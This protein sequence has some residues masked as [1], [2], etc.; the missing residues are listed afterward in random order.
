[1]RMMGLSDTIMW[2]AWCIQ[3]F[4]IVFFTT[5]LLTIVLK[6]GLSWSTMNSQY[7][8]LNTATIGGIMNILLIGTV[9][10]ALLTWYIENVFPGEFGVPN[11]PWF[12]LTAQYWTGKSSDYVSIRSLID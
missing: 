5:S 3:R 9:I 1:M 8:A 4:A 11:K 2:A 10:F 6:A 12:F 7:S